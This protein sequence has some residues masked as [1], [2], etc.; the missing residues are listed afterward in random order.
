MTPMLRADLHVHSCHS[1]VSGTMPFLGAATAIRRRPSL[2][3]GEGARH[4][5]G[6]VD[7][8]RFTIDGALELPRRAMPPT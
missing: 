2:S 6:G 8:S 3:G 7:R 4:G 5:P 1:K